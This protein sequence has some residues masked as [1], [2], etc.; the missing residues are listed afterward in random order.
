[1]LY[2]CGRLK[3][4]VTFILALLLF[5]QPFSRIWVYLSF[6]INQQTIARTLCVKKDIEGNSCQG[7]C[8]LRKQLDKASQDPQKQFP[9]SLKEKS[10]VWYFNQSGANEALP[11]DMG[12]TNMHPEYRDGFHSSLFS[13]GV[14]HPPKSS[15]S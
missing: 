10:E 12:L 7:Q 3:Q 9:E 4:T 6:K 15:L 14:F 1:M 2:F 8:F 11:D 13:K 5:L